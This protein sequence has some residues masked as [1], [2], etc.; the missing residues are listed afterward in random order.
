M[1]RVYSYKGLQ[2]SNDKGMQETHKQNV[3]QKK[4]DPKE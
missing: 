2:N 3:E 4:S 1:G